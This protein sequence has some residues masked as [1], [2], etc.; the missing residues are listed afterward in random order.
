M[1]W[2]DKGHKTDRAVGVVCLTEQGLDM[3]SRRTT[4]APS[5]AKLKHDTPEKKL[6]SVG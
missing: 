4:E 3:S 1:H 6:N 2:G 5:S